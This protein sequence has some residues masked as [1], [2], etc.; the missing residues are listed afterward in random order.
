[1]IV[2]VVFGEFFFEVGFE[3]GVGGGVWFLGFWL[4]FFGGLICFFFKFCGG[5]LFVV[6]EV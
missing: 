6:C 1:M 5:G 2:F 3:V 4:R